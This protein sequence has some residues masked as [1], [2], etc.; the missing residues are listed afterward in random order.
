MADLPLAF[1][2][3]MQAQLGPSYDA[4]TACCDK[5][6][7]KGVRV[8]TLK[9]SKEDFERLA[10]FELDG[11]V[12]WE[13]NGY[14]VK[15]HAI[16]KTLLHTAGAFYVQEPSAMSAVPEL[17][18]QPGDK[19]LDMCAAPGG[20]STQIAQYLGG[21]GFLVSNEIN[22][23]R[24]MALCENI[25]RMGLANAMVTTAEPEALSYFFD[26]FF[27]KILVDAPCSGEGMFRKDK[28]V[29]YTWSEGIVQ[30]CAARQAEILSEAAKMLACGG[31]LVYSTCTFSPQEDEEQISSFL[32]THP[33]FR[34]V[35]MKKLYPHEIRGE[36]HFV[37]VL[38]KTEG[39]RKSASLMKPDAGRA[40]HVRLY[41]EWEKDTL[42]EPIQNV[43][44]GASGKVHTFPQDAPRI[45]VC[46]N[47]S[48]DVRRNNLLGDILDGKRFEPSHTL[49]MRLK[50][51][52][53]RHISVDEETA[54]QYL[55][56]FPVSCPGAENGW[57][58]VMYEGMPL[59][60]CKVVAGT[61]K[62]HLP[63]GLRMQM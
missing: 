27:D 29:I 30:K 40:S 50:P 63:K 47:G 59:G 19:V 49:A 53:V 13:K 12:E 43:Y 11:E 8:N 23:K 16:G 58:A 39:T 22:R 32:E 54:I 45:A 35:R 18:V 52:Q 37:S 57:S 31:R 7:E 26:S 21:E 42:T 34:L 1:L 61:A 3:R 48:I 4:F 15:G 38:E 41:R 55:K 28:D 17:E 51:S 62:N 10:P 25:E 9:I 5:P 24:S 33:D 2:E 46:G 56:G 14:Y 20:K 60:W 36:G 44:S 6:A